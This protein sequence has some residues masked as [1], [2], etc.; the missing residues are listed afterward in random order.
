MDPRGFDPG[1]KKRKEDA[2]REIIRT[3]FAFLPWLVEMID[4]YEAL[5]DPEA[6]FVKAVDKAMPAVLHNLND[7]LIFE[8]G[9]QHF[10]T[11]VDFQNGVRAKD[12]YWRGHHWAQDQDFALSIRQR[13][14]ERVITRQ[15]QK[16]GSKT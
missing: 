10:E 9:Q 6:R 8:K 4:R 11:P 5:A 2:A 16:Y 15:W 12:T 3:Q 13:L 1:V 7:G 14:M